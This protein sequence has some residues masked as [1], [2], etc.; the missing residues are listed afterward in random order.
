MNNNLVLIFLVIFIFVT[1]GV[2]EGLQWKKEDKNFLKFSLKRW[3]IIT[4]ILVLTITMVTCPI[5]LMG[6]LTYVLM[7]GTYIWLTTLL[8]NK[9]GINL[10]L[11]VIDYHTIRTLEFSIPFIMF[12]IGGMNFFLLSAVW[13]VGN[14]VYKRIMNKVMYNEWYKISNM[15]IYWMLGYPLP[16]SDYIYDFSLVLP[17]IYFIWIIL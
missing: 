6:K 4:D 16:Y 7:F 14:W 10:E 17:L 12:L 9:E 1:S 3:F 8:Y 2:R 11:L 5:L 15:K 13:L